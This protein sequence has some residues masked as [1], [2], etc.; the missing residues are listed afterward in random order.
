[1]KAIDLL[2]RVF[3]PAQGSLACRQHGQHAATAAVALSLRL[4]QRAGIRI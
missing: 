4:W 1:V 3:G 2:G